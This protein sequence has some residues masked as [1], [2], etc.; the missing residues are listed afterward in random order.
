MSEKR[1][2][3]LARLDEL[4]IAHKT[5]THPPLHTVAES[6]ALRGKIPGAH[7]KNLFLKCKKGSLWLLVAPEDAEINLKHLHKRL[8]SGRL[9][10][11]RAELLEEVLGVAPGSVTPF[12]V[13]NDTAGRVTVVLDSQLMHEPLINAHPLENTATTTISRDDLLAFL[14]AH[15]HEPRILPLSDADA[16]TTESPS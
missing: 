16:D 15:D 12:A 5:V 14:R 3:L 9:S 13:M 10:F 1:E 6:R 11:G 8:G 4:G 2:K 7:I